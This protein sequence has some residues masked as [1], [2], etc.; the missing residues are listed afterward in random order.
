[1]KLL[2]NKRGSPFFMFAIVVGGL[3]VLSFGFVALNKQQSFRRVI[4]VRQ[5]ELFRVYQLG[6]NALYYIDQSAVTLPTRQSMC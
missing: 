2:H 1:M 6:E 5:G 4:G 3:I